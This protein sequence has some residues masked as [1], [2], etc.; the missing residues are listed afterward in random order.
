MGVFNEMHVK[1]YFPF[2]CV[3]FESCDDAA[4]I[5]A[6]YG[7]GYRGVGIRVPVVSRILL[8]PCPLKMK[9]TCLIGTS[10][11]VH[12]ATWLSRTRFHNI[13]LISYVSCGLNSTLRYEFC[14]PLQPRTSACNRCW[15]ICVGVTNTFC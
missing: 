9:A 1:Q 11:G 5:A 15:C 14:P 8:S 12:L 3:I 2:M 4:C 7:L 13:F 6:G 10:V